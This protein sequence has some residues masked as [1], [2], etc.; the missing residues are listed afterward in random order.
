MYKILNRRSQM[1][2]WLTVKTVA[3]FL[4][5]LWYTITKTKGQSYGNIDSPTQSC[6]SL[7]S[8]YNSAF[9]KNLEKWERIENG[10]NKRFCYQD[11]RTEK[12]V[13]PSKSHVVIHRQKYT[14]YH[15]YFISHRNLPCYTLS[16]KCK[17]KS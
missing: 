3:W 15:G 10:L 7:H 12:K 5:C 11:R 14:E 4:P 17:K 13:L 16:W 6:R 9:L 1:S 8:P 2:A